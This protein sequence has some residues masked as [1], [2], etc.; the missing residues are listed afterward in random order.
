MASHRVRSSLPSL[1]QA[2][3]ELDRRKVAPLRS[4]RLFLSLRLDAYGRA[5]IRSLYALACSLTQLLTVRIQLAMLEDG[6]G[7]LSEQVWPLMTS[8]DL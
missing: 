1:L 5:S 4:A 8:D 7:R 6:N 2:L 3:S